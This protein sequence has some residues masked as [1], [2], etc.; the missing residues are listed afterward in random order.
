M[1]QLKQELRNGCSPKYHND[2]EGS[3]RN[4]GRD[5]SIVPKIP[6]VH[7][8]QQSYGLERNLL[9]G[10]HVTMTVATGILL[11]THCLVLTIICAK[12]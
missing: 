8:K 6:K 10:R 5:R 12:Q 4:F 2:H 1:R 11:T 3:N 7:H 9:Q